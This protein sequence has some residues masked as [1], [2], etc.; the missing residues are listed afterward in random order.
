MMGMHRG[1]EAGR[2]PHID[3]P[4]GPAGGLRGGTEEAAE[5]SGTE[6]MI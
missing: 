3:E 1:R 2:Q 6:G 5:V 4:K